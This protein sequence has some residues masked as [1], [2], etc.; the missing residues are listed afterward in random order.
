MPLC[1]FL[2]SVGNMPIGVKESAT[3]TGCKV[4]IIEIDGSHGECINIRVCARCSTC[5]SVGRRSLSKS[6]LSSELPIA[7]MQ[8]PRL[9]VPHIHLPEEY[10][11]ASGLRNGS[12]LLNHILNNARGHSS[13]D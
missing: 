11:P 10:Q 6:I 2:A 4:D 8:H 13:L 7:V 5:G 9:L 1:S 12:N 3:L